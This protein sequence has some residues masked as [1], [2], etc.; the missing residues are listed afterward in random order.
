MYE[1][2]DSTGRTRVDLAR[3]ALEIDPDCADAYVLL[4][5]ET[6]K[7]IEEA[8]DL[9]VKGVAAGERSLGPK[10]FEE[11]AGHF[12][13]ILETRPYMRARVG[14]AASLWAMGDREAAVG[15]YREML[16]LNPND[17]QG[18]RDLLA[19]RLLDLGHDDDLERLLEQYEDDASAL[20]AYTWALHA[21]RRSGDSEAARTRLRDAIRT[22]RHVPAYLLGRKRLPRTLPDFI[23][24]GDEDE[25][26]RR[27]GE[28]LRGDGD[29]YV[30][31]RSRT[32][33]IASP[34]RAMR[35][36]SRLV[37]GPSVRRRLS[38]ARIWS[39]R[40]SESSCRLP[41]AGTR[42][43]SGS[44]ASTSRVVSGMISVEG[45]PASSSAWA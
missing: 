19:T 15:H 18:I 22:N 21:F 25:A 4:A 7:S 35:P 33:R 39:I 5:E 45:C 10:A 30:S 41:E 8:R 42:M 20:W 14:L 11:D 17:N 27:N 40:R 38:I 6:A 23:G 26:G 28:S 13:G 44:A 31:T 43:R 29:A 2:W 1:A 16:R 36:W 37:R 24:M 32:S 34:T 9:H 3:R 12:W